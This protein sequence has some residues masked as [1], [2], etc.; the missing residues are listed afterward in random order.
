MLDSGASCIGADVTKVLNLQVVDFAQSSGHIPSS[1]KE[2]LAESAQLLKACSDGGHPVTLDIEVFSDNAGDQQ[3]NLALS[4][5][6]AD[7]VREF[8]IEAGVKPNLLTAK[9]FG[10]ARPVASN[11][12]ESGRFAN[13]RVEFVLAQP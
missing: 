9:G 11:A 6:R 3:A 2:N 8:L 10:A 12:T 5:K 1:A 4:Q 7:S 13:R